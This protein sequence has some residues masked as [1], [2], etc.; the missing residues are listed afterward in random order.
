[1]VSLAAPA[2]VG[3]ADKHP[4][5]AFV[6]RRTG[7]MIILLLLLLVLSFAMIHLVPGDPVRAELGPRAPVSAIEA[8]RAE[9]GLDQPIPQQ[10]VDY[11]R[12]LLTGDLGTSTT[13]HLPVSEVIAERLPNSAKLAGI[14]FVVIMLFSLSIG[15]IA[16]IVTRNGRHSGTELGFTTTTGFFATIPEFV[17]GVALVYVF[18]VELKWFP[19]AYEPGVAAYVLPV[20]ALSIGSIAALSRIVRVETLDVLGADYM[21]TAR[22]KRLPARL[23][24]LRHALPNMLTS[25][26]TLGGLL[27]SGLIGATV[28]VENVFAWPG[29]G[30]AVVDSVVAQD[31]ALAQAIMVLLGAT[32]LVINL[33]VDLII[34]LIDPRSTIREL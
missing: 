17:L 24:Y 32:V 7:R 10:F 19:V 25:T 20:A 5:A 14:A 8:R 9:L 29:L 23:T 1:M 12:G 33:T 16:A 2:R 18:G 21:R 27:L 30:T 4:T 28:L 22:S 34:G 6:L 13:S 26:L 11:V 31:Y 15:M 3:F